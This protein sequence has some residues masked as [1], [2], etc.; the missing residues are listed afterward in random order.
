[1]GSGLTTGVMKKIKLSFGDRKFTR[2]T[3][4]WL[5]ALKVKLAYL[6]RLDG[7]VETGNRE[8]GNVYSKGT[9]TMLWIGSNPIT[10]SIQRLSRGR[11]MRVLAFMLALWCSPLLAYETHTFN[12]TV[13]YVDHL[14]QIPMNR[15]KVRWVPV[16]PNM[17]V[18][19][20]AARGHDP[21]LGEANWNND[22][23]RCIIY[24]LKPR[25]EDDI[26]RLEIGGH[27]VLHCTDGHF[28]P[29]RH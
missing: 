9:L 4:Y 29:N 27:E 19:I 14:G 6:Q 1:M 18:P 13:H 15:P 7:S 28:H 22:K 24:M 25:H 23:T 2:V 26:A 12:L 10:G 11:T 3:L 21:V 16:A 5:N 20:K 8:I 17:Y